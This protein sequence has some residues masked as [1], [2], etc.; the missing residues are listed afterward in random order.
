MSVSRLVVVTPASVQQSAAEKIKQLQ[1][2]ARD[3][4]LQQV[5]ALN[6]ALGQVAKLA[7]EIVDGGDLYPVGAQELARRLADDAGKQSFALMA[8]AERK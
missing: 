3:L 6:A 8:I 1:A 4:A 5:E 2:E 7:G